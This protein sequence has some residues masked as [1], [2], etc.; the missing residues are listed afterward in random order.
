MNGRV[1]LSKRLDGSIV[2]ANPFLTGT[3]GMLLAHMSKST[4]TARLQADK[5]GARARPNPLPFLSRCRVVNQTSAL[6]AVT[7]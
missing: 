4:N 2:W 1:K 3:S 7:L 6:I 5:I